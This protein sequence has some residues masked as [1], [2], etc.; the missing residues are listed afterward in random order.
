MWT[1]VSPQ[2]GRYKLNVT[3]SNPLSSDIQLLTVTVVNSLYRL[4]LSASPVVAARRHRRQFNITMLDYGA[5]S[6]I[7]VDY[8]DG[9]A[10]VVYGP[11]RSACFRFV[12]TSS[13]N[14]CKLSRITSN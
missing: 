13:Q 3:V 6:C 14:L 4:T 1:Y 12:L 8:G 7:R 9:S 2:A 5:N 11:D 10:A